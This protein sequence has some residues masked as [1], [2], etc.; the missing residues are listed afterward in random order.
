MS[1]KNHLTVLSL[2]LLFLF[3]NK[4]SAQQAGINLSLALPQGEFGEQVDNLGFGL[5]GEFMFLSPKPRAPFGIGLNLGYYVYGN[6]SR[7][8]PMYNIPEVFLRVD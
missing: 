4:L 8:E 5:S 7:S 6:E 3:S 2:L 1:V